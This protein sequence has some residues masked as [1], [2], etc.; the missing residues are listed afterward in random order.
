MA[1]TIGA[2]C[3]FAICDV[4]VDVGQVVRLTRMFEMR[5]SFWVTF[6]EVLSKNP[7]LFLSLKAYP[8]MVTEFSGG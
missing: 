8:P 3:G 5:F 2:F 6:D 1:N 4:V 7:L